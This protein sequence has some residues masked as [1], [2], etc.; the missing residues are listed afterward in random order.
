VKKIS[1]FIQWFV[2]LL[3]ILLPFLVI[4]FYPKFH[5]SYDLRLFRE[6]AEPWQEDWHSVYIN[7]ETCAY[8]FMGTFLSSG[9]MSMIDYKSV[10]RVI[11]RFRYYLAIVDGLNLLVLCFIMTGLQIKNAPL[12]AG[13]IGLLPTSWIGSSVWGQ[14]DGIGQFLILLFFVLVIWFNSKTRGIGSYYA[15]LVGAGLLL[16]LMLLT[17]QLIY[18]SMGALGSILLVIIFWRSQKPMQIILSTLAAGMAFILPVI[19]VDAN[20]KLDPPYFSHLHFL[21]SDR[22]QQWDIISSLGFNIWV[23]FFK[24]LLASARAPLI[25]GM[26]SPNGLGVIL[27]LALTFFLFLMLVR[28]IRR[29][30]RA[31]QYGFERGQII[32]CLIYFSLVNLSFNLTLTG[33]HERYL[34]HFYPFILMA[35]LAL[36]QYSHFFNRTLL[37]SLFAGALFYSGYLYLYL[38]GWIDTADRGVIQVAALVH[39]SLYVYLLY[40]WIRN[41]TS[42]DSALTSA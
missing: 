13:L 39:L 7:C 23:F 31:E 27:F 38:S 17:K 22:T 29:Q 4:R 1:P 9:V 14:I 19:L 33:T 21:V 8:P 41:S 11:N 28:D 25:F 34:Y 24:D 30:A 26:L 2:L 6:G 42:Q 15:F 18:F 20:L 40:S 5:H 36:I 37:A 3:A 32:S 10:A 35:C 12:W 16:S